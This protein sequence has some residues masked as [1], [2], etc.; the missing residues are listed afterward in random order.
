MLQYYHIM[1]HLKG[2]RV[3][4]LRPVVIYDPAGS[5]N[6]ARDRRRSA[7]CS[8]RSEVGG[9]LGGLGRGREMC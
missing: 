7:G 2:I 6:I 1:L 4:G 3:T 9:H 5:E 8:A